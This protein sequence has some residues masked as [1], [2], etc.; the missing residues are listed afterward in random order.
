MRAAR[1]QTMACLSPLSAAVLQV[2]AEAGQT[3]VAVLKDE[4]LTEHEGEPALGDGDHGVPDQ[5]DGAERKLQLE[6]A[7]PAAEAV[8]AWWLRASSRGMALSEE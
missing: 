3:E 8:D 2:G 4:H 6:E 1:P 7:L 5:S